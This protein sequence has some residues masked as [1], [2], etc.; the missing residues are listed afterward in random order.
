MQATQRR[1]DEQED[2]R[3]LERC[4]RLP[5]DALIPTEENF[6]KPPYVIFYLFVALL[7]AGSLFIAH[8]V[9]QITF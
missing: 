2:I 6:I 3:H 4:W 5:I 9:T 1:P 8:A 7:A